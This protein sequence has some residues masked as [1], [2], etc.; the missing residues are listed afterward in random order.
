MDALDRAS[1]ARRLLQNTVV[2]LAGDVLARLSSSLL[3]LILA[4]SFGATDAGIFT[5]AMAFALLFTQMSFWGLDQVL[6]RDVAPHPGEAAR[7]V[8]GFLFV[9]LAL[10]TLLTLLLWGTVG[11]LGL[12]ATQERWVILLIGLT[13]VPDSLSNI[14]QALYIACDKMA[15]LPVVSGIQLILRLG[16]GAFVLFWTRSLLLLA[17]VLVASSL[18]TLAIHLFITHTRFHALSRHLDAAFVRRQLL[19]ALPFLAISVLYNLEQRGDVLL[20]S[21]MRGTREVGYYGGAVTIVTLLSL[22]PFAYRSALYPLMSQT[23]SESIDKLRSLYERSLRYLMAGMFP[24]LFVIAFGAP[25][26]VRIFG[27]SLAPSAPVLRVLIWSLLFASLTIANARALIVAHQHSMLAWFL[28]VS[29]ATNI[30]LN[31]LLIPSLGPTGSAIAKVAST[32]LYFCLTLVAVR[33]Y[34]VRAAWWPA[35]R[36]PLGAAL[37]GAI[38]LLTM[39]GQATWVQMAAPLLAYAGGLFLLGGISRE[40]LGLLQ[41]TL[42]GASA[43]EDLMKRD[44]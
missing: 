43:V 9:R 27:E 23:Y 7:Y 11:G 22:L 44:A 10:A 26:I 30:V 24:T 42:A 4:R 32:G 25:W 28:A 19:D 31:L 5:T 6:I 15:Y 1:V 14:C 37:A 2:V 39:A 3:F 21:T 20:L 18:I 35:C 17:G 33:R 13:I 40:D 16:V 8:S 29:L 34:V 38:V 12:Y 41:Q 36:G